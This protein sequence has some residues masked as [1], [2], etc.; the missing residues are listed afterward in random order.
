VRAAFDVEPAADFAIPSHLS[1]FQICGREYGTTSLKIHVPQCEK[2]WIERE[3]L[4]DKK[5]RR[6]VPKPVAA[7]PRP[8]AKDP[9]AMAE[10]N[11]MATKQ[12]NERAL[13][14]CP[15]CG[16]TF[17]EDRLVIHLRSCRPGAEAARVGTGRIKSASEAVAAA[18]PMKAKGPGQ[19]YGGASSSSGGPISPPS[20][21][22]VTKKMSPTAGGLKPRAAA[23]PGGGYSDAAP[24]ARSAKAQPASAKQSSWEDELN[25]GGDS[26]PSVPKKSYA[27]PSGGGAGAE[28]DLDLAPCS[29]C[30][31]NF[32]VDRL[33]KHEAVCA[34]QQASD[35]KRAK[36]IAA[37]QAKLPEPGSQKSDTTEA[38]RSKHSEFQN[39]IQYAKKLTAMQKSGVSLANLPPPPRSE[40]ADYIEC[41]HCSRRFA[42]KAADRHIPACANTINKPKAVGGRT[43]PP[44][45]GSMAAQRAAQA[46]APQRQPQR[47]LQQPQYGGG[48]DDGGY[49]SPP[50]GRPGSSSGLQPRS[51]AASSSR[52][53]ISPVARPSAAFPPA[54]PGAPQAARQAST[55]GRQ[56]AA[57]T[58]GGGGEED[59]HSK[60]SQ[61]TAT[62]EKLSKVVLSPQGGGA[63]GGRSCRACGESN[64]ATAR[65][66]NG[67]GGR[68]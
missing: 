6:P 4:K 48:Y 32:A 29:L 64:A 7:I 17:F 53:G 37:K 20:A 30:G 22:G 49:G 50:S 68:C 10:Y 43:K 46:A 34:K 41:P 15:N 60:I 54:R 1:C 31:R 59:L 25:D 21:G 55:M 62:V 57:A 66:C 67:C 35:A 13:V 44:A 52:P 8:N 26:V 61:L 9:I 47:Q 5:D 38:W 12:F 40:N 45:P 2:M 28:E 18:T 16:R 65:F 42:P 63:G 27:I 56:P 36:R 19:T 11:E 3:K 51:S 58:R 23:P 14:P 24:S 33:P 39:A